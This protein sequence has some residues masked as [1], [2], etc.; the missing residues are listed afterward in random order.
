M[1]EST[2]S[3]PSALFDLSGK[4][5]LVTGGSRGLGLQMVLA[6]ARRGA[7]VV[8]ASRKLDA[9][10]AAAAKVSALGRQTLAL[11]VH[12]GRWQD[13]D[14]M[15]DEAYDRFGRIDIL[16]NNAGMSPAEESHRVSEKLFDS[17]VNLNF[18]GPFRLAAR[19]AERMRTGDGGV[20]INISS[21]AA[22]RPSSPGIAAYGA[23][24]AAMNAMTASMA[25]EYAPK[26]RINA[27]APGPFLTDIAD[28]WPEELRKARP[29]A[30][31]RPGKPEEIITAALYLASAASSFTTGS[32]IAVDGGL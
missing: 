24:K 17:I 25:R 6:F 1:S 26:V 7:D 11:Q 30:L 15:L 19:V 5:A 13:I 12:A 4:V 10:E 9:C 32:V 28:S 3:E 29:N 14:R 18:K 2:M 27:I 31:G 22:T 8:I 23:A 16:V 21:S 20:V